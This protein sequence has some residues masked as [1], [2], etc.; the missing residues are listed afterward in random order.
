MRRVRFA[1]GVVEQ[2]TTFRLLPD[3]EGLGL[4]VQLPYS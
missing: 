3:R 2:R 4:H 1:I